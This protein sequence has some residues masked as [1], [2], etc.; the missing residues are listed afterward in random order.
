MKTWEQ[1]VAEE[2]NGGLSKK[3]EVGNVS[4]SLSMFVPVA[5]ICTYFE[6][7]FIVYCDLSS[8]EGE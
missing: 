1:T 2:R 5:G 7:A 8:R 6:I 3:V 4:S